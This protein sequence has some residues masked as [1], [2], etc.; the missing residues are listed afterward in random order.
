[1]RIWGK[2]LGFIFGYMF[3]RLPGAILGLIVGHM[4]DKGYSQDFG[5]GGGFGR[6]FSSP[7]ELKNQSVFFHAL[8]SCLGHMAKA[9]GRVTSDEIRVATA[10]MDQMNLQGELRKEAQNSF[11]EGKEADFPLED[12]L[13]HL[14]DACHARRD[15]MQVFLEMLIQAG[16]ADGELVDAEYRVLE[17]VARRLGFK[18]EELEFLVTA[19]EAELRFRAHQGQGKGQGGA[20]R[21]SGPAIEDAYSILG[22]SAGDDAK[23]IK[24]AYRKLMSEHHPD[25]LVSKG[26]PKQAMDIAK[27][28]AQD[29][30]AAYELIKQRRGF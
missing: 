19:Y 21:T 14:R 23:T 22:V 1:M 3:G 30:Q 8:F 4:F 18:R 24:R 13:A 17:K 15:I 20:G 6:F 11:T 16:F 28:K 12:M 29:I 25:K 9:D 27:T 26:L 7:D 2:L 5:Q 10:L